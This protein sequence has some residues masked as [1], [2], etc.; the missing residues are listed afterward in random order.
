MKMFTWIFFSSFI[1]LNINSAYSSDETSLLADYLKTTDSVMGGAMLFLCDTTIFK[2]QSSMFNRPKLYWKSGIGWNELDEVSFSDV[3]FTFSGMGFTDPVSIKSEDLKNIDIPIFNKSVAGV[4]PKTVQLNDYFVDVK[5][6]E[7][8]PYKFTVD[9]LESTMVS[10]NLKPIVSYTKFD[11]ERYKIEQSAVDK[12]PFF[13]RQVPG[14]TLSVA[15]EK[16]FLELEG[17]L[18]NVNKK[19]YNESKVI[20]TNEIEKII[21]QYSGGVELNTP[22]KGN[23]KSSYCRLIGDKF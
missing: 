19:K 8:I 10:T 4:F 11:S 18:T 3:G 1:M 5:T 6:N 13:D 9:I 12:Y 23:K 22:I 7:Y 14:D 20:R 17:E 16:L 21:E 2:I 15:S